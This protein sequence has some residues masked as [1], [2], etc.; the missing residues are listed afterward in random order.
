MR[1]FCSDLL[2]SAYLLNRDTLNIAYMSNT[3]ICLKIQYTALLDDV[4]Q[5]NFS[6][7]ILNEAFRSL[8]HKTFFLF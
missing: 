1:Q 8:D 2:R 4:L 7:A 6:A 3:K 5:I